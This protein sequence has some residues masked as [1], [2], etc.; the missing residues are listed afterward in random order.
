ME[1]RPIQKIAQELYLKGYEDIIPV[2]PPKIDGRGQKPGYFDGNVWRTLPKWRDGIPNPDVVSWDKWGANVGILGKNFPSF[3]LDIDDESLIQDIANVILAVYPF[4]PMRRSGGRL[5]FM[6]KLK[7]KSFKY[8]SLTSKK[9][10]V[11]VLADG[12]QY[13]IGGEHKSGNRYR[14]EETRPLPAAADLPYITKEGAQRLL[15]K[16]QEL[17]TK[18]GIPSAISGNVDYDQDE[19]GDLLAPNSKYL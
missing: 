13:L 11:E 8:H 19:I 17:L 5:L 18:K 2:I 4:A 9:G 12:Q 6:F 15:K 3:D 16:I 14:W 7:G 10:N 1:G